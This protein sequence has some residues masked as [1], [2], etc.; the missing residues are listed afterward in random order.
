M[1]RRAV[2]GDAWVDKSLNNATEFNAEFQSLITRYAWNDIWGRPGLD[3]TTRRL[4]VLG[5]TMGLA[6]W[7]EF[8]LHCQAAIRS[9]QAGGDVTLGQIKE[10]LM[11]GAIYCGVPAANTA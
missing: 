10:T 11:Q 6:R 9:S 5:M 1:N 7:E 8:E 2:L 3:H 4:L